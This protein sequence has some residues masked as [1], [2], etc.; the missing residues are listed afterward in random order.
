[1]GFNG[2]GLHSV[3]TGIFY[4]PWE[5]I[6]LYVI[7]ALIFAFFYGKKEGGVSKFGTTD[8]IY[9]AIGGAFSVVWEL[10]IGAF[11]GK[12]I[13]SKF[14]DVGFL[15]RL[16]IIFIVA[17][18][19]RKVGVGM[20]TLGLYDLLGDLVHYGFSGEPIF[21]LYEMLT[22]GLFIDILI[23]ITNGKIFA[24][25]KKSKKPITTPNNANVSSIA[26]TKG[27][28]STFEIIAI[29]EGAILGMFYAFI[30]PIFYDGFID[31]LFFG[32]Y[33]DLAYIEINIIYFLPANIIIGAIA[34]LAARRV[35]RV[36]S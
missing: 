3:P 29:L 33:K 23:A 31:P 13:P 25:G 35:A 22:Y 18:M 20:A 12:L 11:F 6:A 15:G 10:Y 16:F 4:I 24:I 27:K 36:V 32:G 26:N 8:I 19:V 1:M 5:Y 2:I 17:G 14:V 7:A 30:D 21:F 34:A 28:V 9:I